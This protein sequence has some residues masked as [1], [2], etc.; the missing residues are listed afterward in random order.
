M[1]KQKEGV[2]LKIFEKEP[3]GSTLS[4]EPVRAFC[5]EGERLRAEVITYGAALRVLEARDRDGA[6]VDVALGYDTLKDYREGG[7]YLGAIVG[8]CANRIA[9]GRFTLGGTTY[10]LARNDAP[11][12]LHGGLRGF[13]DRI[14][15]PSV[16]TDGLHL[17]LE[18]P[19]GEEGYPG[20]LRV[21]AI[22]A[23][24]D[25]DAL[26]IS[27]RAV[28][29]QDTVCNLTNHTYFNLAGAG[30]GSVLSQ[31]LQLFADFYTPLSADKLPYGAV[32]PV[33]G[34]PMD[35]REPTPIGAHIDDDFEQLRLAGGYD[36]NWVV[37]GIPGELR[38]AARA[39]C[40]Q[41]GLVLEVWSTQPG[42]QLYT[43]NFLAG[44]PAG[45]GGVEHANRSAFC[46]ETQAF[47]N[48]LSCP[49]F[50][51][52]V[53]RKGTIYQQKTVFAFGTLA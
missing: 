29:D 13:S 52:P 25:Q 31:E 15:T 6:P 26:T 44:G 45:K 1:I 19:D 11:N 3:F 48:A 12:H 18:S 8:R 40:A 10:K 51:Q 2:A 16:C 32:L 27:Y 43:A 7:K 28:S 22:Y 38:P 42:V 50:P 41:N 30:S 17:T 4:G 35:L 36:H 23:I 49:S 46:L 47:P 14:W 34:T 33:D 20:N 37:R 24:D 9:D 53:L 21:D 5:L 39:V